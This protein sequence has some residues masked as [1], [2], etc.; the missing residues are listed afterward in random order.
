[1]DQSLSIEWG[2]HDQETLAHTSVLRVGGREVLSPLQAAASPHHSLTRGEFEKQLRGVGE[3]Y[4]SLIIAG[5]TLKMAT[6]ANVG[7]DK[8]ITDDLLSRLKEKM[9]SDRINL[10]FPRIPY[11]F[12]DTNGNRI[13]PPMIDELRASALVGVQLDANASLVIPPIPTGIQRT[14]D[15]LKIFERTR[16]E[17][18]T[19]KS[20][21]EMIGF[22]ATTENLE[23]ARDMVVEYAKSGCR[24][25]A[26]D[27]S[28][29]SNQP[30]LMRTV[31]RAIRESLRIRKR[32][33]ENDEKYYLHVFNVATSK[34]SVLDIAPIS[35]V[36]I[37]PYGVDSTSGVMWGGGSIDNPSKLRYYLTDDYGAY[38]R[39]AIVDHGTTCRCPVCK[40]YGLRELYSGSVSTVLSRLQEHR[41]HSYAGEYKRI[42]EKIGEGEPA[43]GYLPYL[44]TKSRAETEIKRIV[45]DVKEIRAGL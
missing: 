38:R 20:K 37:H 4:S 5:E 10:V 36:I 29:A 24:F 13:P 2:A 35:D 41:L 22:V 15:F 39:G 14:K 12:K 6:L 3:P 21:K 28:G 45:E 23:L 43:K 7:Y 27:F 34:K 18:Q 25:F 1:M 11:T 26:V 17:L 31:V 32:P 42:A 19:F 16:V 40:K 8:S 33:R 30:S 9:V 44:Y